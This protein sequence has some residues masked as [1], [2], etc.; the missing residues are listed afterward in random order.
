MAIANLFGV[1]TRV[2]CPRCGGKLKQSRLRSARINRCPQ[3]CGIWIDQS[4][5]DQL[6]GRRASRYEV[7]SDLPAGM[8]GQELTSVRH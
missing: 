2:V 5:L 8:A 4:Q 1:A 7:E 3:G 6:S